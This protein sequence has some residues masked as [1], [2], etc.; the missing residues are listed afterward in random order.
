MSRPCLDKIGNSDDRPTIEI[1]DE[2]IGDMVMQINRKYFFVSV[3]ML[4]M[5]S[6]IGLAQT[7]F[8]MIAPGGGG[9]VM[10]SAVNP[11][12]PSMMIFGTDVGGVFRTLDGGRSYK[13][14]AN[15]LTTKQ[16]HD[17]QIIVDGQSNTTILLATSDGVHISHD[18]G[19][20]WE[21][22]EKGFIAEPYDFTHPVYSIQS[23]PGNPDII[24]ATIG[25]AVSAE[26]RINN[27]HTVY[28]SIDQG[29]SWTPVLHIPVVDDPAIGPLTARV[30]I[31]PQNENNVFLASNRGLYATYDGGTTWY[32]LG[33]DQLYILNDNTWMQ[34]TVDLCDT[35]LMN[36]LRCDEPACQ[37]LPVTDY[38]G[39][40]H[41]TLSDLDIYITPEG[42]THLF[43]TL[44]DFGH[45][46]L[47]AGC[48]EEI[49][50]VGLT[51]VT[52]GPYKSIDGG[53]TWTYLFREL[54]DPGGDVY[55]YLRCNET[56]P[57]PWNGTYYNHIDVDPA[58]ENH[59]FITATFL[60][61]GI[62]EYDNGSWKHLSKV[63][64]CGS[65]P[66]FEGGTTQGLWANQNGPTVFDFDILDWSEPHP[67]FLF[68][69]FRGATLA[70]Y[71]DTVSA[72]QFDLLDS[73]PLTDG[74]WKGNGFTDYCAID[75]VVDES[76]NQLF[77]AGYDA[78]IL[79]S[80]DAGVSW[81][82]TD[83]GADQFNLSQAIEKDPATGFV[84]AVRVFDD[85]NNS[86]NIAV[87]N[88]TD[89]LWK[90]IGG[91]CGI[92][93]SSSTNGLP[94]DLT[95]YDIALDYSTSPIARGLYAGSAQGLYRYRPEAPAG[96]QWG[97][98]KASG[99]PTNNRIVKRVYTSE[100][101]PDLVFFS[102][103]S[104]DTNRV[105][106]GVDPDPATGIFVYQGNKTVPDC[107]S[108][109]Q[110][111]TGQEVRAPHDFAFATT[112][113]GQTVLLAVGK[114][115][116]GPALFQTAFDL[117]NLSVIDWAITADYDQLKTLSGVIL[118]DQQTFNFKQFILS[119]DPANTARVLLGVNANPFFDHYAHTQV[120]VSE[121]GGQ[122]GTFRVAS[123]LNDFPDKDI[124]FMRFSATGDQLYIAP[125]C[126]GL[127]RLANPFLDADADGILDVDDNCTLVANSEQTDSNGD[128]FGNAC[129]AD[130]DNNGF[131]NF[132][133]LAL[134][135][136]AF[137]TVNA[138]ADFDGN[139]FVNFAD[140]AVFKTMFGQPPG[141]TG[142]N[143]NG[144]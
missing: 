44:D 83:D 123:E 74:F 127:Y 1:Q 137:G 5:F 102:V 143:V 132:S 40:T 43:A 120:Y 19:D 75:M 100:N 115:D 93:C 62:I 142:A 11:V 71:N 57:R 110:S 140:L 4:L 9:A 130:L 58:D 28:K 84:Y 139:G 51:R 99:C 67:D 112:N 45:M 27:T 33:K 90:T 46:N 116:W 73:D 124:E 81:K 68:T 15:G 12:D 76:G 42:K 133:D 80:A 60:E 50:D 3:F 21:L 131:V 111:T 135:K 14:I 47:A 65:E 126:G 87:R 7:A 48:E 138:D 104:E 129:D 69:H 30:V 6:R 70:Q 49:N 56:L 101:S 35:A 24:W 113:T 37:P 95:V 54:P 26:Y 103:L 107:I 96:Q 119:A 79:F 25:E 85:D 134:F 39:A 125:D 66:C 59:F 77:L 18:L 55:H 105:S 121:N 23:A 89:N 141:P 52:G 41:A 118:G 88:P 64:Q 86:Q 106:N 72:Y 17:S 78:G 108:L 128:G 8:K 97:Q 29:E 91:S 144:I 16:I 122:T 2:I 10:T 109:N 38:I 63:T 136:S 22:K 117:N 94:I 20:T 98:I 61:A 114:Y 13:M 82:L 36:R 31:H 34:C 53:L 92:N 32:E